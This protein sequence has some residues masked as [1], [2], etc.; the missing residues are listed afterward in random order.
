MRILLPLA[1]LALIATSEPVRVGVWGL[2]KDRIAGPDSVTS[3]EGGFFS[4]L[5]VL[6]TLGTDGRVIDA[7]VSGENFEKL[8]PA[9]GLAAAR[10]WRFRP[11]S[12][13]GKPVIAVG[14][15]PITYKPPEAAPDAS[16][17]FP[18]GPLAESE[19]IL[20]RGACFGTCPAYKLS[21]SGDGTVRFSTESD[22]FKGSAAEVHLAYNG[23][24]VL[25]PGSHVAHV[26][27]KLVAA[28]FQRFRDAHFFG[29]KPAYA[30]SVTDLSTQVLTVR[31]G[32]QSMRVEDYGGQGVGMPASVTA[33]EEAVDDVAGSA[34]WVSGNADTIGQ[35][36]SGGFDFRSDEARRLALAALRRGYL[37]QTNKGGYKFVLAMAERGMNFAPIPDL[38]AT[39]AK[40]RAASPPPVDL[41]G[42]LVRAVA[43]AGDQAA[44]E[45]LD[46][47]GY[48]ARMSKADL[49]ESLR[50]GA[51][52]SPVI[53]R[54][55]VR[56][57]A[58]PNMPGEGSALTAIRGSWSACEDK[59]DAETVEMARTLIDLGG[60]TEARDGLGWTAL[61]AV[62]RPALAAFLIARGAKVN[63]RDKAGTTPVLATDDDRVALLLLR[64]GADPRAKNDQ[65]TVRQQAVRQHMPATLAWLDEHSVQ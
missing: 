52:C 53:A 14:S 57:G 36:A 38:P 31:L 63:A 4:S 29:L 28:L 33:L 39:R 43:D 12:F 26:D 44:F 17:P 8:D 30:A 61:M 6:V 2:E 35:L 21:V 42:A 41:A 58:A 22:G 59:S 13:E 27:P 47:A 11:Q 3:S 25:L 19:I 51:G 1:A 37:H 65:G 7:A 9:P 15:L 55:L 62:D 24:N 49:S 18:D 40:R 54:A 10:Q 46:R 56:A 20:Q 23:S 16:V 32:G 60:S 5:Q 50:G 45:R 34:R 64:A 48:V